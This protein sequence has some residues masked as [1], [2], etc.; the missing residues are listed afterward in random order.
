MLSPSC[1][2]GMDVFG[3][4]LSRVTISVAACL[5]NVSIIIVGNGMECGMNVTVSTFHSDLVFVK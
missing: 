3:G 5:K 1:S 4:F 2:R